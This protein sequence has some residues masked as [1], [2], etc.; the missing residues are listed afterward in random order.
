MQF[1]GILRFC[2]I[3]MRSFSVSRSVNACRVDTS[4]VSEIGECVQSSKNYS[5]LAFTDD[6]IGKGTEKRKLAM[7]LASLVEESLDVDMKTSKTQM[8]LERS[9]EKGTEKRKLAMNLASLVEESIDVDMKTSKTR[10]ELE[11]SLGKGMEKSKL[12]MNLASLV[13]ESLDVDTKTSKTRM[14]LKRSLEIQIKKRVKAQ[15]VNGKFLD[16]MEKVVACPKTL[17]NAYDCVR[18]NSNVDVTSNDHLISFEPMSE[19]L[20]NGNFDIKANT[21]S[22]SSS[23][24]EVVILPNLKLKV[25]QEAIRIVLECVFR[26]HFS[27]ISHG[28]RSGRGHSTALKYI[29]KEINN[30]DW[31]F[32]VNLSKKMDELMMA[33]LI[34]VMEDKIE[35]PNLFA[36]IRTIFD[37]GALNLEFG[38]FPK[39]HGLPQEGVL[40]PILMNI[41]LNLFDQEFFRLSMKYE[42][43]NEYS[44][45][46][47]GGSQ[48]KLRSWIRRQLKGNDSEY[49]GDE[50]D[51]IRVYCC[52]CMDE[53]FLAISGSKDVALRFRSEILDF[54]QNSLHLN[55]HHQEEMVSC[56]ATHGIRFLGC[57]VRRSE[58]ESPAV[59]A[60]HKMK[61]KVELF[62][63]QKQEAWNAWTVWLGKKWLA[64]GLKKVKESEIKHLAEQSP[65]LNQISSFRKAGME[66]D[67]WYKALLKIWLQNINAR[68]AESEET[69]LSKHVVEPSLPQE[70]RDS[71]YEFQRCVEEYVSSETASTIALLPNY[72]PSVKPT[73]VTEI[74]AP[75]NSI[76]KRL[77][78]YRLL[79]N[80]GYP[81]PSPFLILQDD[82]Q[83]IDWFFGVSRRW[84]R[85]YTNCSN[86]SELILICDQV[87]QSCIRTLAAKHRI[88]ESVIEKKFESE[89]S[90]IYSTPDIEQEE[91]KKSP[92]TNGLDND[93][94][95]MYGISYS[96]LCLLSLAR[97]VSQSRPCNC[98]VMGCLSPAPSVYTL[99]VM[100]RQKFPGWKTGFSSSIHPSLNRRRFGLCEKHLKDLYLGH[101]SLQSV[102]FGAWK[103]MNY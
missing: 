61:E 23:R 80:K 102:D 18:I 66:T 14:E 29:K 98:F 93:E 95:L 27:K 25:L 62:A 5:A 79:T 45:A 54:L 71:F 36:F 39:G 4:F 76:G 64:H 86:F 56:R 82:T 22:I 43:I 40:S 17:Q 7:N 12:A 13:E 6:E 2:W 83:I 97:M 47:Q 16:L 55:V 21:F 72:D 60:V 85:W 67:H 28:C 57:L 24:K 53:I 89:L 42:A 26:P 3:N 74:I 32:T 8:E 31:W 70:L 35:D 94:A 101:I 78:R 46:G 50:K 100:E 9:L 38:D 33:K 37:A 96:G 99:H 30:P 11:R 41:Y 87:R 65:S 48:S 69:I 84:F 63:I 58:Q 15:Y 51:N 77:R 1:G 20:R 92:D 49:P 103:V 73:F 44:N 68:A 59:K 75:V 81:C 88:H 91:E 19:E 34:T 10:M 52:R 90:K